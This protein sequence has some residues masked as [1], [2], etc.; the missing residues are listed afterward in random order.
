[1]SIQ[2]RLLLDGRIVYQASD[3]SP[4]FPSLSRTFNKVSD[5]KKWFAKTHA[6]RQR[7][8]SFD[9]AQNQ[10]YTFGEAVQRYAETVIPL[11][12]G[13]RQELSIVRQWLAHPFAKRK[14]GEIQPFEFDEAVTTKQKAGL[15]GSTIRKHLSLASQVY[16]F[17]R[18]KFR[19]YAVINPLPDVDWPSAAPPRKRRLSKVEEDALLTFF[20]S[21]GNAYVAAAFI[22]AIESGMRKSELLRLQW[23]NVN[24]SERWISFEQARKGRNP[25]KQEKIRE[26]PLTLRAVAVL[27][28]LQASSGF[29]VIGQV[30]KTT[31]NAIDCAR[32]DALK[33]TGIKNWRWHDCRHETAS[34]LRVKGV[35]QEIIRQML[36]H[37]SLKMTSDYQEFMKS[38]MVEAVK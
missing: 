11:K 14:I 30:F 15:S 23:E 24:L 25:E 16:D 21:Y 35:Q 5:A 31:A 9:P 18:R 2:K 1:M 28:G 32:K 26:I 8:L 37:D 38:E 17:M 13:A 33:T 10:A 4:G 3:R 6:E 34:R 29:N 7:G 36:G 27:H 12:A 19:M 22:F 20:E